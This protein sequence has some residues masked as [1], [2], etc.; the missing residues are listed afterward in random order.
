MPGILRVACSTGKVM[1]R[2]ISTAPIEGEEVMTI[3]WLLVMSGTASMGSLV[4]LYTPNATSAS[5][6]SPTKSLLRMEKEIMFVSMIQLGLPEKK[7]QH[8]A[9]GW[10][11]LA[12]SWKKEINARQVN[13][14]GVAEK[15][16][17]DASEDSSLPKV[18]D[19]VVA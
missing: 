16:Q 18:K 13:R 3:T 2:S 6:I 9:P 11:G 17:R 1:R 12:C 7:I 10:E 14:D 15:S 5:T 4:R 8:N 19:T